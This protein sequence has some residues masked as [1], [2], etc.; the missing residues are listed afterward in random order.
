M[1]HSCGMD[2]RSNIISPVLTSQPVVFVYI[3]TEQFLSILWLERILEHINFSNLREEILEFLY[4]VKNCYSCANFNE[5]YHLNLRF[6]CGFN[7]GLTTEIRKPRGL[8]D[9]STGCL[10]RGPNFDSQ[11]PHGSSQH[12]ELQFQGI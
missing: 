9:Q 3:P 6:R 5:K 12:V 2:Y 10:S 8:A 4:Y 7:C 11:Q 1:L